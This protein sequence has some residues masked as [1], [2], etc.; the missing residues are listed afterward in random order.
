MTDDFTIPERDDARVIWVFH[1]DL[2]KT[3]FARF[4]KHA[5]PWPVAEALGLPGL[6]P[7]ATETFDAEDISEYGLDRYLTEAHGMDPG[8]VLP[9]AAR[10]VALRGPLVLLFSRE[11]PKGTE[12]IDPRPPLAFIGRYEAKYHLGAPASH[13]ASESTRGH[14]AG[15]PGPTSA[16]PGL[17]RAV[18]IT[19][20]ALAVLVLM[21]LALV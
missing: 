8:S 13:P 5:D 4:T 18:V 9:D 16:P 7:A 6:A 11:L 12:R 20:A 17:R 1:A 15:P 21:V 14:I 3:A 19:M 10:L 2:D